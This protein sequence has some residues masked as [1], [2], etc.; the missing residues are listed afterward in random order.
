[1]DDRAAH[2]LPDASQRH[3]SGEG[4]AGD[5]QGTE[6]FELQD[7]PA[8]IIRRVHQ[9]AGLLFQRLVDGEGISPTQFAVL[10]TLLKHGPLSQAQLCRY[11]AM[12]SSTATMV[13]RALMRRNLLCK[14]RSPR[15]SR[16][17]IVSLR[18]EGRRLALATLGQSADVGRALLAPLSAAEQAVL[19]GLLR[20][21]LAE[22]EAASQPGR[23][24][25]E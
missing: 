2:H 3:G 21:L 25:L 11:T 23:G 5:P 15:D 12:D 1:M 22:D 18:D 4:L 13:I 19:I 8:H 24:T 6:G 7:H 10:A 16:L 14:G 20:R 9:R 17:S